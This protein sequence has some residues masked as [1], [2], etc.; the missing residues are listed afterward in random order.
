MRINHIQ[1]RSHRPTNHARHLQRKEKIH[2]KPPIPRRLC[3]RP[4]EPVQPRAAQDDLRNHEQHAKFRLVD[5]VIKPREEL[6][7]AVGY[8]AAE[9]EA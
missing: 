2:P 9:E 7:R 5:A 4:P 8:Q 1:R 3:A 6:R